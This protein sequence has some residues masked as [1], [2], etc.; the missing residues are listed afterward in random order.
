MSVLLRCSLLAGIS[1][2][3]PDVRV[4]CVITVLSPARA[5]DFDGFARK[6]TNNIY[7]LLILRQ[8]LL[9]SWAPV[10]K[11]SCVIAVLAD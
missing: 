4:H 9:S 11:S 8:L 2:D 3:T 6:Y 5:T 1:T 10:L 7:V